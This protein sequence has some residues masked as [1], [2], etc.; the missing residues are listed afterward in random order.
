MKR[1]QLLFIAAFL[2]FG[3]SGYAQDYK[4]IT[5]KSTVRWT[6]KKIGKNH[7]GKISLKEGTFTLKNGKFIDGQFII[8]M[9]TITDEDLADASWNAK[10]VGHLKSDDFFGVQKFPLSTLKI[11][12]STKFTDDEATVIADL[13]IKGITN[14][15]TFKVK[16]IGDVFQTSVVF[17]RSKYNVK[18]GS[19]KFFASLG[20]NAIEDMIPIDVTLLAVKA[21]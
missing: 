13:T 18:Y 4:V 3:A 20:D 7:T 12:E 2:A 5:D 6:G 14:P 19:G 9:N 10:L 15:V 17:D 16:R 21:K 11:R 1:I 8:D